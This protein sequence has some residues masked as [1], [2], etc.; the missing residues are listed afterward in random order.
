MKTTDK[1]YGRYQSAAMFNHPQMKTIRNKDE[2][3]W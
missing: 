2:S 1:S 3:G